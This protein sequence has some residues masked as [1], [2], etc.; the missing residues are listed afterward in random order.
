MEIAN[1]NN[2]SKS[3][4]LSNIELRR[5]LSDPRNFSKFG[6]VVLEN[7]LS[8]KIAKDTEEYVLEIFRGNYKSGLVPDKVKYSKISGEEYIHSVVN[9]WKSDRGLNQYTRGYIY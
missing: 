9:G 2:T 3:D 6:I 1:E 8:K 5:Q 4:D 7:F